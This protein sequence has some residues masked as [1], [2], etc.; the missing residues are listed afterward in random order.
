MIPNK[1]KSRFIAI[2]RVFSGHV[3]PGMKVKILGTNYDRDLGNDCHVGVIGKCSIMVG[4]H[5]ES[6]NEVF[7]GMTVGISGIDQH[8]LK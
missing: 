7:A 8:I 5:S 2:A 1:D 6:V 4:K 3:A